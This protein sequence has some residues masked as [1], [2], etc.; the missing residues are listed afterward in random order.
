MINTRRLIKHL[1]L[2]SILL[3]PD[4][5]YYKLLYQAVLRCSQKLRVFKQLLTVMLYANS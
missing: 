2:C 4:Y 3:N 1:I 5:M